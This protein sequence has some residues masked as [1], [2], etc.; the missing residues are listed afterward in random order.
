MV[1]IQNVP[2]IDAVKGTHKWEENTILIQINDPGHAYPPVKLPFTEIYQF[3]FW[4]HEKPEL[5]N[6]ISANQAEDLVYVL[7]RALANN[8]NVLVHCHAGRCRSGAV[9]E[10]G[11]MM[12]FEDT[13]R[14]RQPN[15]LVKTRMMKV[16]GWT[17]D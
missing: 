15:I 4:D 1:W 3:S 7:E 2:F 14:I 6:A 12:G 5:E 9:A 16:L 13:R 10:V 8:Q 17:Y 11:V